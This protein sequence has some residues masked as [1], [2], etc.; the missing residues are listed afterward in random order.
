VSEIARGHE[1]V[2]RGSSR[3]LTVPNCGAAAT[4]WCGGAAPGREGNATPLVGSPADLVLE[5]RSVATVVHYLRHVD[6]FAIDLSIAPRDDGAVRGRLRR[7]LDDQVHR[8]RGESIVAAR[9]HRGNPA[10]QTEAVA[11][12]FLPQ[13]AARLVVRDK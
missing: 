4:A 1:L 3:F 2:S 10:V 8:I 7:L 6:P 13:V 9:D 5:R 12:P 11:D